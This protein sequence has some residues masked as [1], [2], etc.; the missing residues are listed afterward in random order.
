MTKHLFRIQLERTGDAEPIDGGTIE[1]TGRD[2][3][4]FDEA[5]AL[6]ALLPGGDGPEQLDLSL[7]G[8]VRWR[9]V[10]IPADKFERLEVTLVTKNRPP[11]PSA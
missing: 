7:P 5:Q 4:A 9:G 1:F 6:V 2:Y 8:F 10:L 11:E 3:D